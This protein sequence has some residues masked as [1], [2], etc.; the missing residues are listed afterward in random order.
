[1]PPTD[2]I[3]TQMRFDALNYRY[4]YD[5]FNAGD[6]L[7]FDE[8]DQYAPQAAFLDTHRTNLDPPHVTFNTDPTTD[9]PTYADVHDHAYWVSQVRLRTLVPPTPSTAA[10]SASSMRARKASAWAIRRFRR[11]SWAA[12]SWP[13]ARSVR[14]PTARL[15]KR[16]SGT[17]DARPRRAPHQRFERRERDDQS[18][19][20]QIDCAAVLD[21]QSDGPIA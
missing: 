18:G 19:A 3:S 11:P 21:V 14:S 8:N 2:S 12:A 15:R 1:M 9:L 13:G 20:R 7:V 4:E 10:R 16:G 6:H 17:R 5:L